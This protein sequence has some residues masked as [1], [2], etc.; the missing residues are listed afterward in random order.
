MSSRERADR[1]GKIE[2]L[3]MRGITW[4]S[5]VLDVGGSPEIKRLALDADKD[6]FFTDPEGKDIEISG[7]TN[8]FM[9]VR[10]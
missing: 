10:S 1:E 3:E 4:W 5:N 8:K 2:N 6:I 9:M 7:F